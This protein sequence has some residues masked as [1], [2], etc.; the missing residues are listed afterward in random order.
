MVW[1]TT[2]RKNAPT[3][4]AT[5]IAVVR[6]VA[7][8]TSRSIVSVSRPRH[9]VIASAPT[10]PTAADS[11]AVATPKKIAPTTTISRTSGGSRSG[12]SRM[13]AS[14]VVVTLSPPQCGFQMQATSTVR[15]NSTVRMKPG[16]KPAR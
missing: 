3:R 1:I 5:T 9:A 12:S 8:Q 13:R 4:I 11:V 7:S 6:T 15:L 2:L 10:M 16:M 14:H